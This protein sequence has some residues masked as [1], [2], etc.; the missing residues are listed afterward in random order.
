VVSSI[1]WQNELLPLA[2]RFATR[3]AVVDRDGRV[4]YGELLARA[5]GIACAVQAA[6][7][8][9]CEPVG[10]LLPNGRDAVAASY[11]ITLAGAAEA[12]LNTALSPDELA[13]CLETAGIRVV[14]TDAANA[15]RVGKL[16]AAPVLVETT[17]PADLTRC[18]FPAVPAEGWGRIG[19]TSGTTG[20]PKGIVHSHLG[21]W[22]ANVL[23]R[24]S[25]PL[26][27][28]EGDNVLLVTPFSHGAALLTY[29]FLDGGAAVTL[30]PGLDAG[31]AL[32]MIEGRE[33][34][35]VF[36]PPTVLAKLLS[37]VGDRQ[38]PD[39]E[40]IYTGTSP[41]TAELY[42]RAKRAFGPV[43]RVT[44][45]KS[46]I[47]NPITVLTPQEADAWYEDEGEP[48]STCVGWPASGVEIAIGDAGDVEG[49]DSGKDG[50]IG[51]V[52]LRARHMSIGTLAEGRFT[53]DPPE[54]FHDTGD[55]GFIDGEGRLH[56]CGRV[57]DVMKSGGYRI[58]R[59]RRSRRRCARRLRRRRSPSS[60][61]RRAIG[62]RS[63]PPSSPGR[64]RRPCSK[65]SPGSPATSGRG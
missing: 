9:V 6:G 25:L 1:S 8:A 30:L 27:P 36:A 14:V 62:A 4:T 53:A 65:P 29:A 48:T 11:G 42:R 55:L 3:S 40:A 49:E 51:A 44:Y 50:R 35:Q 21:R 15:A 38:Y 37:E 7:A 2:Q 61:C 47:W 58:L 34:N 39:L 12:R 18:D 56:L 59:P 13:H 46:E 26:A 23:L 52:L 19:F 20:K 10:L 24:A 60:A 54:A 32:Q 22:T 43:I 33:V 41:L 5:A 64:S 63:S 45:G 31:K 17:E 28:G 57:A 16:G